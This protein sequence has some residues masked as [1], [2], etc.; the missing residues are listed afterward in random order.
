MLHVWRPDMPNGAYGE[1]D[2]RWVQRII[3]ENS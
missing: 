2:E 3:K 1:L